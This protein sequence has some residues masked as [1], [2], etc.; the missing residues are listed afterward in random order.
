MSSHAWLSHPHADQIACD[1]CHQA[2]ILSEGQT[3]IC[4]IRQ[5]QNGELQLLTYAKAAALNL[6]PVEKKPLYHFLPST[7][8]LSLG[9]VGCNLSCTFCQNSSISQYTKDHGGIAGDTLPPSRIVELAIE[10]KAKSISYTYNEPV[11]FFEYA[12]DTAKLAHSHGLK[13]IFVTSGYE[14]HKAIDTIAP[15]L[16][17]MNI[18]LKSFNNTFYKNICGAKL[19]PVLDT[20]QYAYEKGIWIE[21]T[22]LFIPTQN[23]SI[24]EMR[25]IA[26]FIASID[27]NI[28]WHISAFHPSYKMTT[29]PNTSHQTLKTVYDIGKEAGLNYVYTGNIIDEKR[30]N[31][32]CPN[33]NN[34]VIKRTNSLGSEV[35]NYLNNGNCSQCNTEIKGVW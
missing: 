22:T 15:Y 13:N 30:V 34:T 11:V 35:I 27:K 2:C 12:Y 29:L 16:D 8:T 6:D 19:K 20:I 31:T 26:K 33:C 5:V 9:T 28:P 10:H 25:E 7:K 3:G 17:A 23:D 21:I 24:E 32:Y 14:T 18:D 4:G 1:A